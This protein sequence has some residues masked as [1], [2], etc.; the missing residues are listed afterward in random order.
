M[1]SKREKRKAKC[2]PVSLPADSS[3]WSIESQRSVAALLVREYRDISY[4]CCRCGDSTTFT[5]AEQK[6]AFEN[7][8]ASIYQQRVLCEPCWHQSRALDGEL[9]RFEAAW[10]ERRNVL[11]K[12]T[13]FLTTWLEKLEEQ[14]SFNAHRGDT[15]RLRMLQKLLQG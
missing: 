9:S 12:D 2:E 15:A 8:R 14:R 1:V 7:K 11:R 13:L 5:A 4:I 10:L 3:K 6:Q